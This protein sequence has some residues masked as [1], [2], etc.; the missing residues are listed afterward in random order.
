MSS[1]TPKRTH[2]LDRDGDGQPGGSLPGNRTA[3]MAED[4][5][6]AEAQAVTPQEGEGDTGGDT[7]AEGTP[8]TDTAEEQP[9]VEPEAIRNGDTPVVGEEGETVQSAAEAAPKAGGD[10]ELALIE[11]GGD[12]RAQPVAVRLSALRRLADNRW[13]YKGDDGL[14]GTGAAPGFVDEAEASLWVR[15]RVADFSPSAGRL[16]G[17]R[18]TAFGRKVAARAGE[19]FQLP[20]DGEAA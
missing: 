10:E 12:A 9:P 3:P 15:C 18:V 8:V 14:Y 17:L 4:T 13:L 19:L 7:P 5:P 6:P 1:K 16:G 11:T 2:P 20:E